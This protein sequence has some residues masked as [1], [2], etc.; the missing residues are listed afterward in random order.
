MMAIFINIFS[1][2]IKLCFKCDENLEYNLLT[3]VQETSPVS[4]PK[5]GSFH[6]TKNGFIH[7][8]KPKRHC[9]D[10]GRQLV[11][12]PTNKTVS[13]ETKKLI[14]LLLLERI[15]RQGIARVTGV[16]WSWLQNYVNNKFSLVPRQIKVTEKPKS[17][18]IIECDGLWSFV[19]CKKIK[20]NIGLAIDRTTKEIIG[21]YLGDRSRESA[22]KGKFSQAFIDN[23]L[24]FT[25]IFGIHIRQ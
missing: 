5:C 7:N 20:V 6:T 2:I 12:N 24:L 9:Q 8:N 4:C 25:Q 1:W 13:N 3:K 18:L 19:F 22:K 23:V 21:C 17:K 10:F 11:L 16:S 15:S 14:G